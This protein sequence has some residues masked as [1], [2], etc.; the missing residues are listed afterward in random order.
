MGCRERQNGHKKSPP[1]DPEGLLFGL[2]E[3][4]SRQW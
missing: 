4:I 3:E 1:A 2:G